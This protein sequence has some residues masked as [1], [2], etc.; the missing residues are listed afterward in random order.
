MN[1]FADF[2]PVTWLD[3]SHVLV[4][5]AP[6]LVRSKAAK[7]AHAMKRAFVASCF[8]LAAAFSLS[9]ADTHSAVADR[10]TLASASGSSSDVQPAQQKRP[11]M[12]G[13]QVKAA[14]WQSALSLLEG[15]GVDLA[16]LLRAGATNIEKYS[17]DRVQFPVSFPK[18]EC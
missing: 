12:F 10:I 9:G 3:D 8:G 15:S 2:D 11:S 16:K 14:A 18:D 7:I 6:P 5:Q 17:S 4:V 13:E 1:D